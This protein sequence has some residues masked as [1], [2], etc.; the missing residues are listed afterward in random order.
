M[1]RQ[2]KI[3]QFFILYVFLVTFFLVSIFGK[4]GDPWWEYF[5]NFQTMLSGI[6]AVAAAAATIMHMRDMDAKQERRHR[7]AL[8]FSLKAEYVALERLTEPYCETLETASKTLGAIYGGGS[9]HPFDRDDMI[10]EEHH[11]IYIALQEV[12]NFL[13]SS[14]CG[15]AE[16]YF[17]SVLTAEIAALKRQLPT[18]FR[19]AKRTKNFYM[20]DNNPNEQH[21]F[22]EWFCGGDPDNGY[23]AELIWE[24]I[25]HC[26]DHLPKIVAELKSIRGKLRDL[27]ASY[28]DLA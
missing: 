23:G 28:P 24:G 15:S 22:D 4:K 7:A 18:G 14:A 26:V 13:S 25:G 27:V 1:N 6:L 12:E 11:T 19:A 20:R 10:G 17:N 21:Q 16:K 2:A 8:A 5:S 9:L 3:S